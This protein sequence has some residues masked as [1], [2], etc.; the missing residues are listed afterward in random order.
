MSPCLLVTKNL[1]CS[2]EVMFLAVLTPYIQVVN[3]L[4]VS[5][6]DA[7]VVG[8]SENFGLCS[9]SS[10]D[11]VTLRMTSPLPQTTRVTPSD[12]PDLF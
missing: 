3:L 6:I 5:L 12:G 11:N 2:P 7:I 1:N 4:V 9:V 10:V 8:K